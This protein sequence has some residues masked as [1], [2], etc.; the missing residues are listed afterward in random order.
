MPFIIPNESAAGFTDQAE[1]DQRD[2]EIL[3]AG[4][5]HGTGASTYGV[6]PTGVESGCTVTAQG[7]PD[8]TVAVAAG[9][10]RIGGR[11]VKVTAGN[12]TITAADGSNPR[13]D[14][15]VVDTAGTKTAIA[16]TAASNAV[17]PAITAGRV[18]LAAVYVPTSDTAINTNQIT[19]KRVMIDEPQYENIAWYGADKTAASDQATAIQLAIDTAYDTSIS[20]GRTRTVIVPRG[21]YQLNTSITMREGVRLQGVGYPGVDTRYG[22]WFEA[23][24]NSITLL[25]VPDTDTNFQGGFEIVNLGFAAPAGRTG[26]IGM[27]IWNVNRFRIDNCTFLGGDDDAMT[28][29]LKLRIDAVGGDLNWNNMTRCEFKRVVVGVDMNGITGLSVIGCHFVA[30]ST[31]TT[32]NWRGIITV[33]DAVGSTQNIRVIDSEFVVPTLGIGMHIQGVHHMVMACTFEA[34]SGSST[35]VAIRIEKVAAQSNSGRRNLLAGL[36]VDKFTTGIDIMANCTQNSVIGVAYVSCTTNFTD[37][38]TE[39]TYIPNTTGEIAKLAVAL[40]WP[41]VTAPAA[42]GAGYSRMYVDTADAILKSKDS[43]GVISVYGA[44]TRAL[45]VDGSTFRMDAATGVKLGTPPNAIDGVQL[46]DGLTSGA[47][48]NF[49]MPVDVITGTVT[50]RPMWAPG[51]TDGT[52]HTVRWQMNIKVLN[53]ADVTAAGTTV[54]WTGV[55]AARTVNVEVLETGQVSTGVSPVAGDRVRLEIQRLGA[56]GADTYVGAVNLL[57]V[58]IDYAANN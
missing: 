36:M 48:C 44:R 47:Y 17:F 37:A 21:N 4:L 9:N 49:I 15:I 35:T 32:Q 39:T 30:T 26:I 28:I 45:F 16:G 8:M 43:A 31:Q 50:V 52:A 34:D 18:V 12:V 7:S 54:T 53:A 38:G 13:F 33:A 46:A 42:P 2:F 23:G 57:G 3:T 24:A 1:P 27:A 56:D 29:G 58:R 14:L 20:E 5:S 25:T 51:A 40:D 11:F 41:S 55:S 22:S 10:I 19:D 6:G